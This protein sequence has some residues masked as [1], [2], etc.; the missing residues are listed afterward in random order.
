MYTNQITRMACNCKPAL[1]IRTPVSPQST[2]LHS[3]YIERETSYRLPFAS[4]C[5]FYGLFTYTLSLTCQK[6]FMDF[7]PSGPIKTITEQLTE[8]SLDKFPIWIS[9]FG[10]DSGGRILQF[11]LSFLLL[12]VKTDKKIWFSVLLINIKLRKISMYTNS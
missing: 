3:C 1:L 9:S 12:K 6:N 4:G 11:Y 2:F 8:I 5:I 10:Q 7:L